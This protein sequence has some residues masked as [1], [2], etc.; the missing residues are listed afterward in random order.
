MFISPKRGVTRGGG[1]QAKSL[2]N[3]SFLFSKDFQKCTCKPILPHVQDMYYSSSS[4]SSEDDESLS[5][6]SV[7]PSVEFWSAKSLCLLCVS[8]V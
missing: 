6:S 1:N 3:Q 8:H 4:E 7:L 5:S 2:L